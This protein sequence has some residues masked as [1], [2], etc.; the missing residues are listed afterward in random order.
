MVLLFPIEIPFPKSHIPIESSNISA[1]IV[2]IQGDYTWGKPADNHTPGHGGGGGGGR[3][4]GGASGRA[5]GGSRGR[6]GRG[7]AGDQ[8]RQQPTMD[9]IPPRDMLAELKR[10]LETRE[11]D[12][13]AAIPSGAW[14]KLK[15]LLEQEV[16]IFYFLRKLLKIA[17]NSW[18]E[19][20][21]TKQLYYVKT[22]K[23]ISQA[24]IT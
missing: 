5:G 19:I 24:P 14:E 6:G 15:A 4:R 12:I 9:S 3:G 11:S 16:R 7:R 18:G 22:Q 8:E 21:N 2:T 20:V 1:F 23:L 13:R 17:K 10:R